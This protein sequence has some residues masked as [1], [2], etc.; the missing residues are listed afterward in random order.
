MLKGKNA[1]SP[2]YRHM[3]KAPPLPGG[4]KILPK[5]NGV[6]MWGHDHT[7]AH[8]LTDTMTQHSKYSIPLS[9]EVRKTSAPY[10]SI[11][12][13][14]SFTWHNICS[15]TCQMRGIQSRIEEVGRRTGGSSWVP[16]FMQP[17]GG[18]FVLKGRKKIIFVWGGLWTE[19]CHS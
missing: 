4:H 13:A 16:A 2:F 7:N 6:W 17:S 10:K 1:E 9:W 12:P 11:N 5:E 14:I 19:K 18:D 3:W 15:N 8:A